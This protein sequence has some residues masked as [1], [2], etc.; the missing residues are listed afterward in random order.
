MAT[1]V[2]NNSATGKHRT[3]PVTEVD[4]KAGRIRIPLSGA[5]PTKQLFPKTK[6]AID[7]ILRGKALPASWDPRM[8]PDQERSGVVA[9]RHERPSSNVGSR[10]YATTASGG[11]CHRHTGDRHRGVGGAR[12]RRNCDPVA[13][14]RQTS[15]RSTQKKWR[16]PRKCNSKL[17]RMIMTHQFLLSTKF[18]MASESTLCLPKEHRVA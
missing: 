18:P 1:T 9:A 10:Q 16:K 17:W 15:G 4:L 3:Q 14:R 11:R 12:C 7:L 2:E 5:A 8:G 6:C 13:G